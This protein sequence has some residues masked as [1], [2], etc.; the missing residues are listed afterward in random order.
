MAEIVYNEDGSETINN[1]RTGASLDFT[2][3]DEWRNGYRSFKVDL[4]SYPIGKFYIKFQNIDAT[5]PTY[6]DQVQIES[7]YLNK[8]TIYSDGPRS[9]SVSELPIDLVSEDFI[10]DW[11]SSG[12]IFN[13]VKM[14]TDYP[15]AQIKFSYSNRSEITTQ[16]TFSY[17]P[18][19][20]NIDGIDYYT[21]I[22]VYP[23]GSNLPSSI[24]N[25]KINAIIFSRGMVNQ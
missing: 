18:I 11:N 8:S 5:N 13:F 25:G 6:L 24:T 21:G 2:Y 16:I 15:N 3:V 14:Y 10:A 1:L 9:F 22:T 19:I 20:T 23:D 7:N 12:V 17:S 4:S